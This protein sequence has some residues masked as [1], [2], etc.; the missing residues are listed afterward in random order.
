MRKINLI[1]LGALAQKEFNIKNDFTIVEYPSDV[2]PK[3]RVAIAESLS[4]QANLPATPADFDEIEFKMFGNWN[5]GEF[6]WAGY[7]ARA[8]I[9]AI[10]EQE[11][12]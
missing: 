3:I 2:G 6:M 10:K 1:H 4:T 9:L 11:K 8:N 7:S 5:S 12:K